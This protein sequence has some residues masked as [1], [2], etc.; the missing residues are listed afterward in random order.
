MEPAVLYCQRTGAREPL[1]FFGGEKLRLEAARE[2]GAGIKGK[3]CIFT[4]DELL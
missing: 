4:G 3:A 1:V 2:I